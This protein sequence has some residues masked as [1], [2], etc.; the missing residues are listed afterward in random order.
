MSNICKWSAVYKCRRLFQRLYQVWLQSILQKGCSS[1]LCLDI[2][3]GNRF[4]IIG[5]AYDNACQFFFQ[6][7]DIL[8]QTHDRHNLAGYSDFKAV[9]SW[10]AVDLAAHTI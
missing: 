7:V 9:F 8:C 3:N 10:H 2:S 6:V 4:V 5:V 1:A